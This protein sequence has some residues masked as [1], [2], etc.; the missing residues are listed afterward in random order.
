MYTTRDLLCK[1]KY[2]LRIYFFMTMN[3]RIRNLISTIINRIKP[4]YAKIN[5]ASGYSLTIIKNTFLSFS[6]NHGPQA[7]AGIAYY[8]LFSLFPA[9]IILVT[10]GSYFLESSVV[11]EQILNWTEEV[12]P[13]AVPLISQNITRLFELRNA[14]GIVAIVGILWSATGVFN[15]LAFNINRAFPEAPNRNFLENRIVALGVFGILAGLL[16]LNILST[17]LFHLIPDLNIP[18]IKE[19]KTFDT[20]LWRTFS[21]VVPIIFSFLLFWALYFWL[22]KT[23][24]HPKAAIFGALISSILWRLFTFFFTNYLGT[25]FSRY[26]IIYGSLGTVVLLMMFIYLTSYITLFGAHL[27]SAITQQMKINKSK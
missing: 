27:T 1:L 21:L 3:T 20:L 22:P 12:I 23:N 16:L 10:V 5:Q 25:S 2:S 9:L 26:E 15:S 8:A 17:T 7:A 4:I 11:Q 19:L 14:F 13:I 6:Q 24:V 18:Y